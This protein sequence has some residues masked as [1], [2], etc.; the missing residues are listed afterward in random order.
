[1]NFYTILAILAIST[2]GIYS[3]NL[4]FAQVDPLIDI[5]FLQT[6]VLNTSENQFHISNEIT[7]REFFNGK[8]IRVSGQVIEGFPYI[9]YSKILED[10]IDTHGM[11]FIGGKFVDLNF[12]EKIIQEKVIIEKNDDLAI[13]IQYTQR[14]YSEKFLQI[15]VKIFE[16]D[17]NKLNNFYQKDNSI[18]NTN[19]EII[20]INEDSQNVYSSNGITNDRGLYEMEYLIPENSK[21][22][23]LTVTINTENENLKSS[24]ILQIF[25][26]GR[27]P[28]DGAASP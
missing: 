15:D 21:R 16:K 9:T 19:I 26:L 20:V 13:V 11:I 2:I 25:S 27:A 12:A 17:R 7:I 23:T 8:I 24:K 3:G 1:M 10:E 4:A 18:S 6:G 28:S 5:E 14:I 22:E